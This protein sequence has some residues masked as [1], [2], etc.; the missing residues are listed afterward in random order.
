L[1]H[2]NQIRGLESKKNNGTGQRRG[3]T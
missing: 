3:H 2:G 1:A